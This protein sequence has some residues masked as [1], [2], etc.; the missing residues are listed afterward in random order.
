[1]PVLAM[2]IA[3][4]LA[5]VGWQELVGRSRQELVD[6]SRQE[7]VGKSWPTRDKVR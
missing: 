6:R 1:V 2:A 7:L 4:A 3:L 5:G